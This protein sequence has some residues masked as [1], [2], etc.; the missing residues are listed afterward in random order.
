M[1][2]GGPTAVIN[3]TLAG[4]VERGLIS[5]KV[6]KV[7]GSL[8]GIKGVLEDNLVEIGEVLSSPMEMSRLAHTPSAAIGS[9]RHKLPK[10]GEGKEEYQKI[11][12]ILRKHNIG[13]MVCI[14]GND[15][16]DT[17]NKLSAYAKENDIDDI[18]IMGGPK[19]IDNDLHSM[20]HSPGFPSAARYVGVT[21]SE[22]WS[23]CHVYDIPAVTIVEVMGRHTGWLTA[24]AALPTAVNGK[25]P[26]LIYLPEVA[27][28]EERFINDVKKQLEDHPAVIIAVSEGIKY[29]NGKFVSEGDDDSPVDAFGHKML[30]GAARVL[31][32]LVQRKIGCK[33]RS[34]EFNLMQ[35]SAGHITSAVDLIEARMLGATAVD[36]AIN[37]ISG[38]VAVLNRTSD[39]PY[40]VKYSS[41]PASEIANLEKRVPREW[42]NEEGNFVTEEMITYLKP[43]IAKEG[44]ERFKDGLPTHLHFVD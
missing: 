29:E 26:D 2:S 1:Q 21:F 15:S 13:Y 30:S 10:L 19:T 25:G 42:I 11:F 41:A 44:Q 36:R 39:E 18:F 22:L 4:G 35:R 32:D 17:V 20:D 5:D 23:D 28:D 33:V 38:E 40:R 8:Y 16:M 37:G 24:S 14:G 9:A 27:F 6:D 31:E 34:V 43:L 3:A 7:Y 12:E